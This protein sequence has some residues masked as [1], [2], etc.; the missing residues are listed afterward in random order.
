MYKKKDKQ[1]CAPEEKNRAQDMRPFIEAISD[2]TEGFTLCYPNAGEIRFILRLNIFMHKNESESNII[3]NKE[4][5][6][7]NF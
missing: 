2:S 7:L 1:F 3:D 4:H 5:L 6:Q